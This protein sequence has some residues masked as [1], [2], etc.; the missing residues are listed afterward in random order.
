M[1][2]VKERTSTDRVRTSSGLDLYLRDI[3]RYPL[4]KRDEEIALARRARAGDRAAMDTLVRSN[5]RFVV[6]IAKRYA[7]N[8]VPLE[9]LINDGNLGL[10][11]AVERFDPERGFKFISYAVWWIRQAIRLS[12]SEHSRMIRMPM[13][14]VALAQKATRA[15]RQLEQH[16]G[17]DPDLE[18]IARELS[19]TKEEIEEVI[20]MSKAHLSLD[21]PV[22]E[23]HEET[24][25][26]DQIPD[27]NT[28]SPDRD[29]YAETLG[30]DMWRALSTLPERERTILTR[31][32][33]VGGAEPMTL[34][35][36]G[37]E[38]GYTRER[39]RQLKEQAIERLRTRPKSNFIRDYLSA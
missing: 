34:E 26:V 4:L 13:N 11:K 31:Y 8:G 21:A 36:I 28:A 19:V 18:D 35:E 33:G 38:M 14:R 9:D 6:S 22:A 5:L 17:R 20:H 23:D 16:L 12:I 10:V 39:I 30:Q 15:S 24:S 25:F 3:Q 7:G 32:Y 2:A 27:E 29:L 37:R 1:M